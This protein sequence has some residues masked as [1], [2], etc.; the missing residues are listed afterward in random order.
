MV[1]ETRGWTESLCMT[2]K[3]PPKLKRQIITLALTLVVV[4]V[5]KFYVDGWLDKRAAVDAPASSDPGT[6]VEVTPIP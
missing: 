6:T 1:D 5:M 3:M 4:L 2:N